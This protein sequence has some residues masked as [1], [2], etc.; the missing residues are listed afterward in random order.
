MHV[1]ARRHAHLIRR[2]VDEYIEHQIHPARFGT[3]S[4]KATGCIQAVLESES[5][6]CDHGHRLELI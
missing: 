4:G 2:L 3:R 1:L 5:F 6:P